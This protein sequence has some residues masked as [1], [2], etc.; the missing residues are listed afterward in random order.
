MYNKE[1]SFL[2]CAC[3]RIT[4]VL[5]A[6][7]LIE[8]C[9][10]EEDFERLRACARRRNTLCQLALGYRLAR[11]VG[12]EKDCDA[13]TSHYRLAGDTTL[14]FAQDTAG[15]PPLHAVSPPYASV[16]D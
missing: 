2:S 1:E 6:R 15:V 8:A 13:A 3:L 7:T 16:E 9:T 11:G 10:Q 12:I 14:M 4:V 5:E